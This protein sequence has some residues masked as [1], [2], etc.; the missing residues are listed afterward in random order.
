MTTAATFTGT[1][2]RTYPQWLDNDPG[3]AGTTLVAQPLSTY[4]I[5]TADNWQLGLLPGD[6][7]WETP[8]PPLLG[9]GFSA[10]PGQA[11]AG[12]S[13]AGYS[14]GG[15]QPPQNDSAILDAIF[16]APLTVATPVTAMFIGTYPRAYPQYLDVI[17]GFAGATLVAEPFNTYLIAIADAWDISGIPGD[18]LWAPAPF[19]ASEFGITPGLAIIGAA[20]P[21]YPS[22]QETPTPAD[23]LTFTAIPGRAVIGA[24]TLGFPGFG[25]TRMESVL[26][27]A[28]AQEAAP[29]LL[30]RV[31]RGRRRKLRP[32]PARRPARSREPAGGRR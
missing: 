17:P 26:K 14:G 25:G 12:Q 28:A 21:G 7:L 16:G 23:L 8:P 2:S 24:M 32:A 5:A 29:A 10:I 4:L 18:G 11:V 19:G 22:M 31:V 1:S 13:S 6:G 3:P 20:T 9:A 15:G 27:P 30:P